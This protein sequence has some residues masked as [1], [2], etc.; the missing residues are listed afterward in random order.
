MRSAQ[1][2]DGETRVVGVIGWPVRHSLSPPMQN[3]GLA[4]LGLNWVY[5]PFEVPPDQVTEAVR[6]VRALGL[7]GINV[8]VPHKEAVARLVDELD[9][10]AA[11]LGS[12]NTVVNRE[13]RL[14][15]YSTDG[16]G[17]VRS[18]QEAGESVAGKR[19]ALVGAGGS[20][21][22]VAHAVMREG[23]QSLT[24]INRTFGRARELATMLQGRGVS[25]QAVSLE[26]A[27]GAVREAQVIIDTTPVGMHPHVDDDPVVPAAWLHEGQCVCDL[28]YRPRDT[29]LLR[30]ARERGAKTVGGAGMLLHQGA[31]ALELWTGKPAPVAVMRQA[32]LEALED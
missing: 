27:E 29:V 13:G 18:L 1:F 10:A 22:A 26:E 23:P 17:F 14:V 20:A 25:V 8:T 5:V 21:R 3:A 4:A 15:G 7:V 16:P 2:V 12:V 31:I 19:V 9:P 32:L 30:A 11:A 6:A 28:V 24:I